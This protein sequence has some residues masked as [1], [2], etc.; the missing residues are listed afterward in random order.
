MDKNE[1]DC[2]REWREALGSFSKN[3]RGQGKV[4][5]LG[6]FGGSTERVLR[7]PHTHI[8]FTIFLKSS[9]GAAYETYPLPLPSTC[10][11][12]RGGSFTGASEGKEKLRSR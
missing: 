12:G 11:K 2:P 9:A 1:D 3:P 8:H 4:G 10:E 7:N 6:K 5:D